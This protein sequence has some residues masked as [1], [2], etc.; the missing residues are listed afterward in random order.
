[1]DQLS[2]QVLDLS[3]PQETLLTD[4]SSD[5]TLAVDASALLQQLQLNG[6]VVESPL[7]LDD[8]TFFTLDSGKGEDLQIISL[9]DLGL[10][11]GNI[12]IESLG[13]KVPVNNQG[14]STDK[15][16]CDIC[17][18]MYVSKY[19]L[20][21][22]KRKVHGVVKKL[23]CSKCNKRF[24]TLEEL[25]THDKLHQGYRPFTCPY[26]SNSFTEEQSYKTHIKRYTPIRLSY[27]N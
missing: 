17:Q 2:S 11:N 7:V 10:Q 16:E 26:C 21:K 20:S 24:C 1:M 9:S 12:V 19:V 3:V 18:Q 27:D 14:K 8:V 6:N 22:H 23:S 4:I 15:V 13:D 5:Q 25:Q